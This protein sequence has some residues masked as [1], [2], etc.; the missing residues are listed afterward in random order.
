[1]RAVM[2]SHHSPNST[3]NEYTTRQALTVKQKQLEALEA[4]YKNLKEDVTILER[5]LEIERE[6]PEKGAAF[7]IHR[8]FKLQK[9][10]RTKE[11]VDVLREAGGEEVHVNA[12]FTKLQSKPSSPFALKVWLKYQVEHTKNCPW[13]FGHNASYYVLS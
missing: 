1:M 8:N 6:M 3:M 9:R 11:V 5:A 10:Q 7:V 12:L 2:D 13:K 4:Q